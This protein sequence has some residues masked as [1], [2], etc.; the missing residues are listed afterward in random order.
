MEYPEIKEL[1]EYGLKNKK[2]TMDEINQHLPQELIESESIDD[3]F[4]L[5]VKHN[6]QIVE[7]LDTVENIE[8]ALLMLQ[9]IYLLE[10]SA[11]KNY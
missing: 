6:I 2:V 7:E 8:K 11:R 4:I 10:E 1:I 9:K 5:L 3:V